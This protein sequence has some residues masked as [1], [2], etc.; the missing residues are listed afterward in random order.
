MANK[1]HSIVTIKDLEKLEFKEQLEYINNLIQIEGNLVKAAAT[2]GVKKTMIKNIFKRK[3][4]NYNEETQAFEMGGDC[5]A[6]GVQTVEDSKKLSR[7]EKKKAKKEKLNE[8]KADGVQ[9]EIIN[10]TECS[11][12]VALQSQEAQVKMLDLINNY[13]SI[14]LMLEAFS[15]NKGAI[16]L[17]GGN[18]TSEGVQEIIEVVTGIQIDLPEAPSFKTSIR[19]N[20]TEW[21]LFKE[22]MKENKEFTNGDLISQALREYRLKHQ[23]S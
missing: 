7:K 11:T 16:N 1:V 17:T 12:A 3:A 2:L 21:E 10:E 9:V 20:K 18:C 15:N 4:Y 6:Q 14:K 13:D 23:K 8:S 22:F 19:V 5:T